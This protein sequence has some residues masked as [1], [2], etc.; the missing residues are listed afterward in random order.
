MRTLLQDPTPE[1]PALE[2][3]L[4]LKRLQADLCAQA[5][6]AP[7]F[8]PAD[9][10]AAI[11]AIAAHEATHAAA[12]ETLIGERGGT[13]PAASAF[14][15]TAG[16]ALAGFAFGSGQLPTFLALAQAFADLA[17][18]AIKGR[19]AELLSDTPALSFAMSVHS[20]NAA[21]AAELRRRRGQRGWITGSSR[22]TL[23]AFL[24]P[25]YAGEDA[26]MQGGVNV[27]TLSL[28]SLNGG[29]DATTQAFDEPLGASAVATITG[30]FATS[31]P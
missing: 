25:V 14:D 18:R 16:G 3:L 26:V 28:A 15:F 1:V 19:L 21:H 30:M 4:L 17:G 12:L 10:S 22:D 2:A 24:Q 5:L 31:A 9:H 23:P 11:L 27:S 6:A 7:G 29:V 13:P 20:V 8:V